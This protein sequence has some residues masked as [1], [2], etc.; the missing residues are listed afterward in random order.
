MT[1]AQFAALMDWIVRACAHSAD[2]AGCQQEWLLELGLPIAAVRF[3]LFNVPQGLAWA[4]LHP[5]AAMQGL[6]HTMSGGLRAVAGFETLWQLVKL[7]LLR[8]V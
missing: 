4:A 6:G 1:E 5:G 8:L 2:P 3:L 7:G